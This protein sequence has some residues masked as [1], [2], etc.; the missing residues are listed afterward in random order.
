MLFRSRCQRLGIRTG[1]AGAGKADFVITVND[2]IAAVIVEEY[3]ISP[4][5]IK[6]LKEE[7]ETT[8]QQVIGEVASFVK[9]AEKKEEQPDAEEI[10]TEIY[11][12]EI[13]ESNNDVVQTLLPVAEES[14][15]VAERNWEE[16]AGIILKVLEQVNV[17]AEKTANV[18]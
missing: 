7:E 6:S 15:E 10:A 18:A 8:E 2:N 1:K 14:S 5:K 3:G 9:E 12:M 17:D 11:N 16:T 4:T 13:S